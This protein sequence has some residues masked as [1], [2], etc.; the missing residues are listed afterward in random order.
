VRGS[1]PA[2]QT[3]LSTADTET[4]AAVT[5]IRLLGKW[6]LASLVVRASDLRL[7]GR[8][9]DYRTPRQCCRSVLGQFGRTAEISR[10]H[11]F[12]LRPPHTIGRL[13][14][15][16]VTAVRRAYH[17]GNQPPRPTQPPKAVWGGVKIPKRG[18]AA[19]P[20]HGSGNE[21]ETLLNE[22]QFLALLYN[23]D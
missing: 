8:E 15:G 1:P 19:E 6:S 7:D 21:A 2:F 20:R 13:V 4:T 17:L 22:V 18:P 9:L 11:E 12:N 5:D 23:E 16:L 3:T 14:L 10:H